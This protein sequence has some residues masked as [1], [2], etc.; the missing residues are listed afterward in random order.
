MLAQ[1][2]SRQL[3][4]SAEQTLKKI[5]S[6]DNA[7]VQQSLIAETKPIDENA[8]AK[9]I[10]GQAMQVGMLLS[11][12]N[13]YLEAL[14]VPHARTESNILQNAAQKAVTAS[15]VK[16]NIQAS[17]HNGMLALQIPHPVS[18]YSRRTGQSAYLLEI[19][20]A[21][22]EAKTKFDGDA[23]MNL[24]SKDVLISFWHIYPP[25]AQRERSSNPV[26]PDNDN[27]LVKSIID[28]L[29]TEFGFYDRG[30]KAFLF[31]GTQITAKLLPMTYVFLQERNAKMKHFI[32][33]EEVSDF[34]SVVGF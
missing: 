14:V 4:H 9:V 33:F 18:R 13:Q 21:L 15:R 25:E 31:H 24:F 11:L 3:I 32:T 19:A 2:K 30:D 34:L 6:Y 28:L 23:S 10:T 29:S 27:Y 12:C 1:Y 16:L 20:D 7:L 8:A 26:Y 17:M 22:H 5:Q